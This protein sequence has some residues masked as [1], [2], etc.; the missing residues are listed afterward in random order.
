MN[1]E[2]LLKLVIRAG[3]SRRDLPEFPGPVR[4]HLGR[5]LYVAQR[6]DKHQDKGAMTGFGGV[7]IVEVIKNRRGDAFR[8]VHTLRCAGAGYALRAFRKESKTGRGTTRWDVELIGKAAARG[9]TGC[10]RGRSVSEKGYETGGRNV[11]KDIVAP[12][13]GDHFVEAQLVFKIDSIMKGR[14]IKQVDAAKLF[15]VCQPDVSNDVARRVP[16][17]F[18]R[19]ASPPPRG[20]ESGCGDRPKAAPWQ[21]RRSGPARGLI[22]GGPKLAL[23]EVRCRYRAL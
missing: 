4:G 23:C 20:P 1:D 18:R 5:A 16:T 14:G 17:V 8:A 13:A 7:G 2:P 11:F 6:D 22:S 9:Q 21:K 10:K 15:G 3:A 12:D 19:T